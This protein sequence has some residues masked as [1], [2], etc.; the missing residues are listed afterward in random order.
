MPYPVNVMP[1]FKN[2]Q[3]SFR[4]PRKTVQNIPYPINVPHNN[5][6]S[7][8]IFTLAS[9]NISYTKNLIL[10]QCRVAWGNKFIVILLCEVFLEGFAPILKAKTVVLMNGHAGTLYSTPLWTPY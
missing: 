10:L 4:Y 2:Q 1:S 8:N 5:P 6:V 3:L 7:R 9:I